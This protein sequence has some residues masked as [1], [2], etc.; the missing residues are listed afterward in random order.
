VKYQNEWILPVSRNNGVVENT[1]LVFDRLDGNI[2][3]GKNPII[4]ISSK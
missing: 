3:P 4:H 2:V 1:I